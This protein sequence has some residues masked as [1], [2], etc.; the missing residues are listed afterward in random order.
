MELSGKSGG[1]KNSD[2][3]LR[4]GYR[5]ATEGTALEHVLNNPD[6]KPRGLHAQF[7]NFREKVYKEVSKGLFLGG[8]V[9][10]DIRRKIDERDTTNG[11]TP[12][13]IYSDRHGFKRE[14]YMANGLLFNVQ[15]TTR[16]NQNR[17]YK[18]MYLDAG[19]RANQTWLGST[20]MLCSFPQI[21]GNM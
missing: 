12:Y 9:S 15:Y 21:S 20:R 18:G 13:N 16:D 2:T 5:Q 3:R 4:T 8:G 10:F 6:R 11:L 1:S 7:Y 19:F 17:A 14:H